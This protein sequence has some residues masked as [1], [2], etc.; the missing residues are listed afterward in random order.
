MRSARER[1]AAAVREILKELPEVRG[2][3]GTGQVMAMRKPRRDPF[4]R[5]FLGE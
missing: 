3:V 2:G 4:E 1:I 5:G